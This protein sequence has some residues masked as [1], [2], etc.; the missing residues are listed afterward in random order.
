MPVPPGPIA[1]RRLIE[2]LMRARAFTSAD[3]Q[4]L[5]GLGPIEQRRLPR[6]IRAGVIRE[7]APGRYYLDGPALADR[8]LWRR[9]RLA[10]MMAVLLALMALSFFTM[11][12]VAL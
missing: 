12:R 11:E 1:E 5:T 6:L 4:P 9:R 8:Q 3:A 2:R 10:I 7:D